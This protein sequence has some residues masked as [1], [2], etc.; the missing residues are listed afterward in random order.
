MVCNMRTSL[1]LLFIWKAF[2][3]DLFVTFAITIAE[4]SPAFLFF[5]SSYFS[6]SSWYC[7]HCLFLY[8]VFYYCHRTLDQNNLKKKGFIV[9]DSSEECSPFLV[10]SAFTV[11]VARIAAFVKQRYPVAFKP[12]HLPKCKTHVQN[13]LR[14][15]KTVPPTG[16]QVFHRMTP[17]RAFY[18]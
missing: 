2:Q 13:I 1:S 17:W 3:F 5:F 4:F 16:G 10:G 14:P 6:N 11:I 15:P 8:Y 12:V 7:P 18:I 9:A